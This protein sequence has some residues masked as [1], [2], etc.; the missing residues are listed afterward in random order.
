MGKM[1]KI[2]GQALGQYLKDTG[3]TAIQVSTEM[4]AGKG[5][6][7]H[8]IIDGRMGRAQYRFM[9]SILGV[10]PERFMA[11]EPEAAAPDVD[12]QGAQPEPPQAE[13][14]EMLGRIEKDVVRLS[15]LMMDIREILKGGTRL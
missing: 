7:S 9:C 8:A 11:R 15:Q 13:V 5:Y 2:D 12:G 4:D 3:K 6:V 14:V 1:V 10:P